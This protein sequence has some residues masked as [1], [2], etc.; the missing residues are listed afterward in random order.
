MSTPFTTGKLVEALKSMKAG[1][2]PGPDD[3]HPGFLLHAGN[4][5][6]KWLCQYMYTCLERC[7]IPKIWHKATVIALPK[8]NRPK[9]DPK[10]YRPILLLCIPF[11]LLERV[12]HGRIN[13]IIDPQLP[14]EQAGF[15]KGRSTVDQVTLLTQDIEDCFEAKETAGAVLVYLTTAYDNILQDKEVMA[16]SALIRKLVGTGWGESPSTPRTSAPSTVCTGW[17]LCPSME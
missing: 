5:A 3:I 17:I 1:K 13:P 14:H 15:R 8:P 11:K 9:D 7:K 12:V 6:T 16:R 2:A 10:S 4:D